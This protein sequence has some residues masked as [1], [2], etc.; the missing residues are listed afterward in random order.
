MLHTLHSNIYMYIYIHYKI[1]L[2]V[3]L[4]YR[5]SEIKNN[6]T[7][8]SRFD[9]FCKMYIRTVTKIIAIMFLF[10][11]V[12]FDNVYADRTSVPRKFVQDK[13]DASPQDSLKQEQM[14]LIQTLKSTLPS[15]PSTFDREEYDKFPHP[16]TRNS[17]TCFT[18]H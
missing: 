14:P 9:I 15:L 16:Q 2:C 5:K 13:T 7:Y 10:A 11:V 12:S 4:T 1:N 3:I 6:K 18:S 17:S 8:I